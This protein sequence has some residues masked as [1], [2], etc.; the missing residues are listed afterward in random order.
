MLMKLTAGKV[1]HGNVGEIEFESQ[2][3][4][5]QK[6]VHKHVDEIDPK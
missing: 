2:S 6:A 3:I 5:A 4:F 1:G